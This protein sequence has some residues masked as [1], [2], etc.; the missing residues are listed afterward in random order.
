VTTL[1]CFVFIARE[2][3]GA[4][5]A[6]HSLRPF[7]GGCFRHSRA[8]FASRNAQVCVFTIASASEAIHSLFLAARWIASLTLAMTI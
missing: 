8:Q 7:R 4:S 2:A 1:V 3:A 5:F 6:R